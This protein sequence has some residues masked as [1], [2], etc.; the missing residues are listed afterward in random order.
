MV[1]ELE[2]NDSLPDTNQTSTDTL[3]SDNVKDE[4]I[5]NDVENMPSNPKSGGAV[6]WLFCLVIA[7]LLA[8]RRILS[9]K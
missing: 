9:L 6:S 4:V 2:S 1:K 8:Q 3:N 7:Q 5:N